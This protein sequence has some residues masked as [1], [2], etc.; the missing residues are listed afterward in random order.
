MSKWVKWI[1]FKSMPRSIVQRTNMHTQIHAKCSICNAFRILFNIRWRVFFHK[2]FVFLYRAS[3]MVVNVLFNTTRPYINNILYIARKRKNTS[4][5][6]WFWSTHKFLIC[7]KVNTFSLL[8]VWHRMGGLYIQWTRN[9]LEFILF[10][11]N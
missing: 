7:R 10:V 6:I 5:W 2:R 4:Y 3:A 11:S 1:Y 8:I 9:R